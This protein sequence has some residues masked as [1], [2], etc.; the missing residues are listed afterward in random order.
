MTKRDIV[1]RISDRLDEKQVLVSKI[2]QLVLDT[3]IESLSKGEEVE[4]RN[5]GIFR[6]KSRKAKIGR[7]PK[8][9]E[10]VQIPAKKVVVFRP[11]LAM[12]A[13]VR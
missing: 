8:T 2:V 9:G 13:R 5:F 3:I 4:L 10:E 1:L 6:I 12:K 7:N 11:G